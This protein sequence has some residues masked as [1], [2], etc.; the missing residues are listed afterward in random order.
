MGSS[1]PE[2]HQSAR[3]L[4]A[5]LI[6]RYCRQLSRMLGS[7]MLATGSVARSI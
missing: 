4:D 7:P 5:V 2:V 3:L 1:K 6:Q